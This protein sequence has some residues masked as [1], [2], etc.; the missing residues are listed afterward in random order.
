MVF[1]GTTDPG[2]FIGPTYSCNVWDEIVAG[3]RE[4]IDYGVGP[5]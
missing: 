5:A 3:S 2:A 4:S 1:D